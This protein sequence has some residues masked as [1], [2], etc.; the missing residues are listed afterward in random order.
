MTDASF[1]LPSMFF[2]IYFD[3]TVSSFTWPNHHGLGTAIP[4]VGGKSTAGLH[5]AFA[6]VFS[7]GIWVRTSREKIILFTCFVLDGVFALASLKN[8]IY[9]QSIGSL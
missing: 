8:S 6:F 3:Q 5:F 7:C 2:F 1:R 9:G 4:K